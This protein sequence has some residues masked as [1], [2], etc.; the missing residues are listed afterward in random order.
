MDTSEHPWIP[1]IDEELSLVGMM[2]DFSRDPLAAFIYEHDT[3]WNNMKTI[4]FVI[5]KQGVFEALYS[6]NDSIFSYIRSDDPLHVT[7]HK[8]QSDVTTQ[9]HRA[10]TELGITI[11]PA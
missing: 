9:L 10:L 1:T 2:D 6:D 8:D 3:T 11:N 7:Y 5:E 4:R